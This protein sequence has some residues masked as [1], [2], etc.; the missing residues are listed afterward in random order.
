MLFMTFYNADVQF[1]DQKFSQRFYIIAKA[2]PTIKQIEIFNK[3]KFAKTILN[4]KSETFLVY[5]A[6]LKVLLVGVIIYFS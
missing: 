3:K 2:L 5:I 4:K 1:L 6:A